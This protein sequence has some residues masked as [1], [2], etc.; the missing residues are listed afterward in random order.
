MVPHGMGRRVTKSGHI[1][2]SLSHFVPL[3]RQCTKCGE[4]KSVYDFSRDRRKWSGRT[5][6]C[7][8]CNRMQRRTNPM[9]AENR[10]DP[11]RNPCITCGEM[12][13][14]DSYLA[15]D[16]YKC[17]ECRNKYKRIKRMVFPSKYSGRSPEDICISRMKEAWRTKDREASRSLTHGAF[18]V[19]SYSAMEKECSVCGITKSIYLFNLDRSRRDG[20]E[21]KCRKCHRQH[22]RERMAARRYANPEQE[23]KY[24]KD[25]SKARYEK[26]SRVS[27]GTVTRDLVAGLRSMATECPYC[28]RSL[29]HA[30]KSLDH[31]VP[32]SKGG[33]HSADNVLICCKTCNSAK[34]AKD[35]DEWISRP[36]VDEATA[37]KRAAAAA[38]RLFL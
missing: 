1:L 28:G 4:T 7:L 37:T 10:P 16:P 36:E 13:G 29:S 32:I 24:R 38:G 34:G 31:I 20:H 3:S 23:A 27:D 26:L 21:P 11:E 33:T 15:S 12:K 6:V 5:A 22:E 8:E 14:R 35:F 17:K 30:N 9:S 2:A 18:V 25:Y 19:G